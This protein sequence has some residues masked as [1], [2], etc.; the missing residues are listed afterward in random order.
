MAAPLIILPRSKGEK[1]VYKAYAFLFLSG[2]SRFAG[3]PI[4]SPFR[5]R[6]RVKDYSKNFSNRRGITRDQ[7]GIRVRESHRRNNGVDGS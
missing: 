2:A 6:Y 4:Y 3:K 7:C 1:W 5:F